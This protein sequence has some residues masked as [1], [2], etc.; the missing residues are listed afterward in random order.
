MPA[1]HRDAAVY[2]ESFAYHQANVRLGGACRT[3]LHS[4]V[5]RKRHEE[6]VWTIPLVVLAVAC[7]VFLGGCGGPSVEE[8]IR[9]DLETAFSEVSPDNEELLTA[10]TDSSDG[11][12]ETLGIDTQEFA[13]AYLDGFTHEIKEVAVDE[14][15][16]TADATVV[17]KMKSL[18]AIMSE[19]TGKFQEY[20]TTIDPQTVESEEALYKEAG[21][22]LMK[23]VKNAEP[24][25][26]EC[27][28]TY[29]KDDENTWS[30]TDSAE[31]Q[32]LEAM[33]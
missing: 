4:A 20:L 19:F 17:L 15:A 23:A 31:Q 7:T 5:G 18:T 2:L 25:E 14:E 13:K 6:E 32:I 11:G 12:F 30:A 21:A 24:E 9:E 33:M 3:G 8:L 10:M 26:S 29:E 1:V 27:V 28:F 22:M 16:G